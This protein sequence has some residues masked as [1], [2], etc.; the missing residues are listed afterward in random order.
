MTILLN[1]LI[2][3]VTLVLQTSFL[4]RFHLFGLVPNLML[5]LIISFTFFKRIYEAY[6]FA[7]FAGLVLDILSAGPFGFHLIVF[8]LI[9]LAAS[10][11]LKE[12]LT[13]ISKLFSFIF[14]FVS[15]SVFYITLWF[16]VSYLGNSFTL[17]GLLFTLGQI[18]IT[19]AFFLLLIPFLKRFFLWQG[20]LSKA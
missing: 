13:K 4:S 2:L 17:T 18:V 15:T 16:Y 14:A 19:V 20:R 9:V 6:I 5:I 10:L 7:F 12:D 3:I 1:I 11:I 8:M